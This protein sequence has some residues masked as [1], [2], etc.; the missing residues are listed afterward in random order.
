MP[1]RSNSVRASQV[2]D[3][4]AWVMP[5][6]AR[7]LASSMNPPVRAARD[8][9]APAHQASIPTVAPELSWTGLEVDLHL[10]TEA[11]AAQVGQ[12]LSR[13]TARALGGAV[14]T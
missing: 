2:R 5:R 14:I 7:H 10:L 12:Q 11:V 8:G 3:V 9:V 6:I 4:T 13:L 1:W